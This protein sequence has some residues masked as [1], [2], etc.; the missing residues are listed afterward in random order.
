MMLQRA[1]GRLVWRRIAGKRSGA[2][3]AQVRSTVARQFSA[4]AAA[5]TTTIGT[6]TSSDRL[7][8]NATILSGNTAGTLVRPTITKVSTLTNGL[9]VASESLEGSETAT[10]GIW[11]D[12]GS[13]FEDA[14]TNGTAHFL[15]HM[16]FKV[17]ARKRPSGVV[18]VG[19]SAI[20][21]SPSFTGK[22]VLGYEE[23]ESN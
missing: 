21:P 17:S 1:S 23:T 19:L 6:S 9:R 16:I 13:R 11:I 8:A 10:V 12:A 18:V 15:E 7:L 3:L 4:S 2:L 20:S 22:T 14:S 5:A